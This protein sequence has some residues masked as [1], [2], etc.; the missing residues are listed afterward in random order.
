MQAFLSKGR[1]SARKTSN[2]SYVLRGHINGLGGGPITGAVMYGCVKI[3]G[4]LGII[5]GTTAVA[6]T[7]V[8]AAPVAVV[9]GAMVGSAAAASMGV[10][11]AVT[12]VET[13]AS[14]AFLFGVSLPTP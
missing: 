5:G 3:G 14:A 9:G 12:T 13:A 6:A 8:A 11:A 10:A 7:T 2:G 4:W 1:I